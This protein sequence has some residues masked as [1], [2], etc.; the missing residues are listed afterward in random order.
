MATF[1]KVNKSFEAEG[2]YEVRDVIKTIREWANANGLKE[3]NTSNESFSSESGNVN[4]SRSI[5]FSKSITE[6]SGNKSKGIMPKIYADNFSHKF[7]VNLT[8]TGKRKD[9]SIK[10]KVKI[11]VSGTVS[12]NEK[13][14]PFFN[15]MKVLR[16]RFI[17]VFI[18]ENDFRKPKE[19]DKV[20]SDLEKRIKRTVKKR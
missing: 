10:G 5:A 15:G 3:K 8:M 13:D 16:R 17:D 20:I 19:I 11:S 18:K 4:Y 6:K 7:S 12:D 9:N 14:D 2:T 1:R